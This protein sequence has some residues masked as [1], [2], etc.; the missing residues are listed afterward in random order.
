MKATFKHWYNAITAVIVSLLGFSSCGENG[1][2]GGNMMCL[3]GTPT[4]QFKV[5]GKVTSEDGTPIQG[6]KTVLGEGYDNIIVYHK[7]STFTDKDGN[8]SFEGEKMTGIPSAKYMKITFEDVDGEA[9]GGTF[10]ND[11]IKKEE[12]VVKNTEKG[13]DDWDMGTYEVTANKKLKKK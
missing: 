9:N 5:K 6:I 12:F 7:D 13:D 3:Y 4:S 8:Y 11:T 1:I 10:A 2:L